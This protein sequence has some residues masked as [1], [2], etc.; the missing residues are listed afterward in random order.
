MRIAI[1]SEAYFP[2]ISGV[3]TNLTAVTK[4]L[5]A[6]GHEVL[7][8]VSDPNTRDFHEE[9]G[10]FK[11]P[12]KPAKNEY[13]YAIA[14]PGSRALT[15]RL[16]HFRPEVIHVHTD[17][18]LGQCAVRFAGQYDIPL[19]F[20]IHSFYEYHLQ[21]AS[22]KLLARQLAK[23]RFK[24]CA[25]CADVLVAAHKKAQNYLKSAKVH[26]ELTVVP[27]QADSRQFDYEE[28]PAAKI[29]QIRRKL[30]VSAGQTLA[31][32][33]GPLTA[34]K[35]ID[36]LLEL[37]AQGVDGDERLHLAVVGD[38]P[39]SD[40]LYHTAQQLGIAK[41]VSFVGAVPYEEMPGYYAAADVYVSAAEHDLMPM[42]VLEAICC[43][44]PAVVRHS[45]GEIKEGV[46]GFTYKTPQDFASYL[47]QFAGL[48]EE[49]RRLLRRVVRRTIEG[50][51]TNKQANELAGVYQ[52]AVAQHDAQA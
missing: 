10:V 36:S 21:E 12:A 42:A 48:D 41:Q 9:D 24:N 13:G 18:A 16:E 47:K 20:Q 37:W 1:F 15:S 27:N 6:L 30:G 49:G 8:I 33:A 52:A 2:T 34:Q 22:A 50:I 35:G 25:E 29:E 4:N 3:I 26:R 5:R 38:G 23:N 28:V 32:C 40:A 39:Q 14:N 51:P 31:L 7:L 17:T 44:T 11:C 46:N 43:G 45:C 19:V